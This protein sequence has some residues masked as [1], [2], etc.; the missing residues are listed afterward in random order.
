MSNVYNEIH[1]MAFALKNCDDYMALV[2]AKKAIEADENAKSM[3][4]DFM[5]KQMDLQIA[6]MSGKAEENKEKL[7]Q[8]QKLYEIISLNPNARDYL[9]YMMKFER[10]MQDMYKIVND[11]IR[12]GMDLFENKID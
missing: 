4:K 2:A 9:N 12:E 11:S 7:E 6:N 10:I 1:K 3:L 5:A 8:V